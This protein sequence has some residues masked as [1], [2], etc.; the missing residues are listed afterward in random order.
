MAG[1]QRGGIVSELNQNANAEI[2]I[3]LMSPSTSDGRDD[4]YVRLR[5]EERLSGECL[6]DVEIPAGRFYRLMQGSIQNWPAIVTIHPERLRKR[7]RTWTKDLG[8]KWD[9]TEEEARTKAHEYPDGAEQASVRLTN[10]G[11]VAV[12]RKWEGASDD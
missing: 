7:M 1:T 11:W 12:Y 6:V 10:R 2:S 9:M 8:R 4:G 3:S 5:V